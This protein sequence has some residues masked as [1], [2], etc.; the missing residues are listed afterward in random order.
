M[1]WVPQHIIGLAPKAGI[2]SFLPENGIWVASRPANLGYVGALDIDYSL[3][4]VNNHDF[5]VG[6]HVGATIGYTKNGQSVYLIENIPGYKDVLGNVIDYRIIADQ[7]TEQNSQLQAEIPVQLAL[8]VK[9]FYANLGVRFQ[10]PFM[11]KFTQSI[12]DVSVDAYYTQYDVHVTDKPA[13]GLLAEADKQQQG[14]WNGSKWGV[15]VAGELGYYIPCTEHFMIG[16]G[17]FADY[18]VYN[19][20]TANPTGRLFD[21]SGV[22]VG[23]KSAVVHASTLSEA[24]TRKQGYFD[25]GAKLSFC[26]KL[27]K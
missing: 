14:N 27:G 1:T 20:F 15:A 18:M 10:I 4:F 7:V 8:R 13:I 12:G 22:G 21:V 23:P 9:G 2:S 11:Q 26:I 6:V 19:Q 3:L 16:I 24:Y 5:G 17:L 25:L